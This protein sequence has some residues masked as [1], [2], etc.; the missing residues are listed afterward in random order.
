L[1]TTLQEPAL[2]TAIER[3]LVAS[4]AG[5]WRRLG[6][7]GWGD[8][9]SVTI[10]DRRHFVKT[11]IGRHEDMLACE[12]EGLRALARTRTVRVPEVT[13]A[14]SAGAAAFLAMEWLEFGAAARPAALAARIADM[15]R[16]AAPRGPR[17]ERFGW[18]RDNWIGG[19]RQVNA[20]S[21]EWSAFFRDRRLAPQLALACANGFGGALQRDGERLLASVP[22]LLWGH[23]PA[24]SLVHGDL[25]SGNAATLVGG[26]P[27][28]FD[29]AVYVGD[30]E[31][32]LA[33]TELFGGF[34]P[35]FLRAYDE[36]WPLAPG[37]ALRRDLYNL[38]HLLNHL[39]LFGASY[40]ARTRRTLAGLLAADRG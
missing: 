30:R 9:W 22:S 4:A 40:L 7:T 8:A 13:A 24:P 23:A 29:P 26:D 3:A 34:G 19:N 35:E 38:Y 15:H 28:V 6:A 16:T 27:V 32:D 21:D 37:Y 12:A 5:R 20:W 33:M 25:W 18:H 36:R 1:G 31:V 17:G 10:G 39:N 2:R 14:G 11:A